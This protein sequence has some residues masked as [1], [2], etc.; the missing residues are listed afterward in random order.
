[1]VTRNRQTHSTRPHCPRT[2][3]Q[4]AFRASCGAAILVACI[5]MG[6]HITLYKT[7]ALPTLGALSAGAQPLDEYD[8]GITVTSPAQTD[9]PTEHPQDAPIDTTDQTA[10]PEH[11]EE[12]ASPPESPDKPET[13]DAANDPD[14]IATTPEQPTPRH[15]EDGDDGPIGPDTTLAEATGM[16]M[17]H[18]TSTD[19]MD[20]LLQTLA[21][22]ATYSQAASVVDF[23]T[24]TGRVTY[25]L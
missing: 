3:A 18:G 11:A 25:A 6:I 13:A 8:L 17:A 4:R 10:T 20:A 7:D 5:G 14:S 19:P 1:M 15:I 23:D 12:A 16:P 24:E 9:E 21:E 22:Q 2:D